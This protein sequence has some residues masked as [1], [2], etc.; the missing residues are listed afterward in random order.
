[1]KRM[2]FAGVVAAVLGALWAA[3][4]PAQDDP[5][6]AALVWPNGAKKSMVFMYVDTVTAPVGKPAAVCAQ[7][8]FFKRG[9]RVVFRISAFDKRTGK[10]LTA[11]DVRYMYVKIPGIAN[12]GPAAFGKHGKDPAAA[13]WFWTIGWTIPADYPLGVVAFEVVVKTKLGDFGYFMQPPVAAAQLT[14]TA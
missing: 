1:M 6:S 4:V 7:T 12:Q 8:N 13:P 14:V 9:Q 5:P 11:K 3:P 2:V 10:P